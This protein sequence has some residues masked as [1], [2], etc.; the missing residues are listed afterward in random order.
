[1]MPCARHLRDGALVALYS[2]LGFEPFVRVSDIM[3][4]H[5]ESGRYGREER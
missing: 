5:K 4:D 2:M 3:M 1:M